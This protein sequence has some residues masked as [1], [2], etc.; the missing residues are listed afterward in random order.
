MS[1][2]VYKEIANKLNKEE[3]EKYYNEHLMIET[4][5]HFDFDKKYFYR[6]FDYLGI[7]RRTPSE[8]TKFVLSHTKD[9]SRFIKS[10]MSHRGKPRSQETRE[11]ISKAQKG[12]VIS[13]E[14]RNKI[15]KSL[16]G[17]T[18][19]NKG[20]KGVQ[21]WSEE[22]KEKYINSMRKTGWY[23]HKTKIEI[24]I[25]NLLIEKYGEE[26]VIYQYKEERYPF[27]CDFYIKSQ[28]LFI[29]VNNYWTHNNHPFDPNNEDD[30]KQVKEW[31]EKSKIKSQY[32]VALDVWTKRDVLKFKTAKENNLNYI[33]IYTLEEFKQI[34][35][36]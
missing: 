19:W 15:S 17:N 5:E 10:G 21:H 6:I 29:E 18:P 20:K 8:N 16:M 4:C 2:C 36:I 35:S 9:N 13:Q 7:K 28:D 33:A 12:K 24:E 34:Y 25:H 22:Q 14:H 32:L 1:K 11:K 30:L 31:E 27:L 3:V 26:D 23:K